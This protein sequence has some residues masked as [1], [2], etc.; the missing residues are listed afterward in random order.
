MG[1]LVEDLECGRNEAACNYVSLPQDILVLQILKLN[2]KLD[3]VLAKDKFNHREALEQSIMAAGRSFSLNEIKTKIDT[4]IRCI[5]KVTN[6][7][8]EINSIL[9]IS[10][11]EMSETQFHGYVAYDEE[12]VKELIEVFT[13]ATDNYT[14]YDLYKTATNSIILDINRKI[15]LR[16]RKV[17]QV[18]KKYFLPKNIFKQ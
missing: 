5:N 17:D 14:N 15:I 8:F 4:H 13:P 2:I 6:V 10:I 11:E 12:R 18:K 1:K 16:R 3:L 7:A 9:K